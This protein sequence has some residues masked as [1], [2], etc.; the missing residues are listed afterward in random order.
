MTH[1]LELAPVFEEL[2]AR[3][4]QKGGKSVE[5]YLPDLMRKA[6]IQQ[7][8]P[9]NAA[10]SV[11]LNGKALKTGADLLALW[12]Q[13]GAFLPREDMP[14]S[15]SYARQLREESQRPRA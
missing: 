13:E 12:E 11:S 14:D 9:Q 3:Q 10:E 1:T 2:A 7:E 15:P 8:S 5:E 6:L 4:A